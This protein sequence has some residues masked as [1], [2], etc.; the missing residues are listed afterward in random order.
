MGWRAPGPKAGAGAWVELPP[1]AAR[2]DGSPLVHRLHPSASPDDRM[3]ILGGVRVFG[4]TATVKV[5][6]TGTFILV[7]R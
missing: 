3:Y 1:Y 2:P 5:N 7:A 4:D 6:F